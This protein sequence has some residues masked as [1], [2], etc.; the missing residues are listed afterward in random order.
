MSMS[1][2]KESKLEKPVTSVN[3]LFMYYFFFFFFSYLFLRLYI[4]RLLNAPFLFVLAIIIV[5]KF[6]QIKA[7]ETTPPLIIE[8]KNIL[9]LDSDL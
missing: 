7:L 3:Y 4:P 8:N 2:N 5:K 9:N 6:L 1:I